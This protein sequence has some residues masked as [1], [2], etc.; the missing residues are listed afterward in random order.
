MT[1]GNVRDV[2]NVIAHRGAA[3][4]ARENT[5]AAFQAAVAIG[6]AGIELDVRRTADGALVVNHDPNLSDGRAIVAC[7]RSDLPDHV[8]TLAAALDA[9]AGAFV[10]IEVKNEPSAPDFDES[11]GVAG[12]VIALLH[13]R[14]EP[15]TNWLV[16]SFRME[17]I[18][19]CHALEPTVAT[20][21]LTFAPVTSEQIDEV[22][23][24]GHA[25][26]HPWDPTVDE[27]LVTRC[28]D[29]GLAVNTWTCNDVARARQLA[30]WGIDGICTDIPAE[31]LAALA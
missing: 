10:N 20:A 8:P 4:A 26:I 14:S 17:S 7:L 3:G 25:A 6:A 11:E 13:A 29:R 18:D 22:V 23:K 31:L 19:R 9:C 28:H 21:W 27:A 1:R 5:C 30:G 24:R 15:A 2:T 12:A 16:S